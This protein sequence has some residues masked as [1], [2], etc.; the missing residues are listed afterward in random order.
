[1]FNPNDEAESRAGH[2]TAIAWA[3]GL[4][5]EKMHVTEERPTSMVVWL[6][7]I[8]ANPHLLSC[9]GGYRAYAL[10]IFSNACA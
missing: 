6:G 2:N 7:G 9:H 5:A 10:P 1:V 3:L 4:A 8:D